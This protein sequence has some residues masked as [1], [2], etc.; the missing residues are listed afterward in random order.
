MKN[1]KLI[2]IRQKLD[3]LDDKMLLIVKKRVKLVDEVLKQKKF[4][5]EI[6]DKRRI[7]QIL[8][9][10]NKKS[11]K[12]KLDPRISNQIWKSMINSFVKYEFR[13]FKKK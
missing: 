3:S 2:K 7:V 4:K 8:K 9:R 11:K 13:N 12:I 10:I 5:K 1:L 6:I